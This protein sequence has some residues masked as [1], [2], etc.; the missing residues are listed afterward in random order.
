M[1]K[2]PSGFR[3]APEAPAAQPHHDDF[4]PRGYE[5]GE[6]GTNTLGQGGPGSRLAPEGPNPW[7]PEGAESD[8]DDDGA[9]ARARQGIPRHIPRGDGS[10]GR[11]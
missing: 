7:K 5:P 6:L 1:S 11:Y 3:R 4:Y 2:N 8:G 10:T 9:A